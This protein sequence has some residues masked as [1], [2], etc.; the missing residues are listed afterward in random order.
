MATNFSISSL[1]GEPQNAKVNIIERDICVLGKS[2]FH[3]DV[4][5]GGQGHEHGKYI[6]TVHGSDCVS[7]ARRL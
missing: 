3:I 4:G 2:Q 7:S 6:K 5:V 1:L